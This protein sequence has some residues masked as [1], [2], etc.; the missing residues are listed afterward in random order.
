MYYLFI[1]SYS[2]QVAISFKAVEWESSKSSSITRSI[3]A[4]S[5]VLGINFDP[6]QAGRELT[7]Y[8]KVKVLMCMDWG[9]STNFTGA[10]GLLADLA[11]RSGTKMPNCLVISD[12]QFDAAFTWNNTV[13]GV[14]KDMT[15]S[16]GKPLI[17]TLNDI[18]ALNHVDLVKNVSFGMPGVVREITHVVQMIKVLLR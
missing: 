14:F 13:D 5:G 17:K 3:Y 16:T 7:P 15:Q 4:S 6:S 9:C 8:E 11:N 10:F 1:K 18:L 12:M 2:C